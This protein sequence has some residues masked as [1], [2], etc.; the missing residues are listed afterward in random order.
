[1]D[2]DSEGRL[3]Y[4]D[5]VLR[6]FDLVIAAIHSGFRQSKA[7]LS[8]RIINACQNRHVHIIAH[9]TGRLWSA[10][11]AYELDFDQLLSVC[12]DTNTALEIN[13]FP[14]RLDLN[15]LNA[16]Q[17][18]RAGVRLAIG[19]D[20]HTIDGLSVMQFGL[21]VARRAWLEEKDLLNTLPVEKFL[22]VIKK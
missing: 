12:R 18:K 3:D 19:T 17:A 9:P 5:R 10:R 13:A 4:S 1:M 8:Q 16:R 2:I 11:D 6:E 20:A 22:K 7:K 14:A 15:D 21:S